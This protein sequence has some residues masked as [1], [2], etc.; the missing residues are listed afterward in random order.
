MTPLIALALSIRILTATAPTTGVDT[1]TGETVTLAEELTCLVFN[2]DDSFAGAGFTM[3]GEDHKVWF[4]GD[5]KGAW[6][7]RYVIKGK[8]TL[9]EKSNIARVPVYNCGDGCH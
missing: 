1:I 3:P 6:Y 5:P 2:A 4:M 8:L 7:V 9:G